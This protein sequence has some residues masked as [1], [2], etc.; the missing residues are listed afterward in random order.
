ML[1]TLGYHHVH[2]HLS[3]QHQCTNVNNNE[4]QLTFRDG[5]EGD[6]YDCVPISMS[7]SIVRVTD[8]EIEQVV[9]YMSS[10]HGDCGLITPKDN[11]TK[12]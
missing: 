1:R 2:V 7:D 3:F 12:H 10:C 11:R 4:K 9:L 5:E 6:G 8:R